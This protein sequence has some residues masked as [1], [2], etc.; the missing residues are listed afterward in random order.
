MF[1]NQKGFETFCT[2]IFFPV[3][4]LLRRTFVRSHRVSTGR[5]NIKF[6]PLYYKKLQFAILSLI[7]AFKILFPF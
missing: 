5:K 2:G 6:K 4:L 1:L 3:Q 7:F